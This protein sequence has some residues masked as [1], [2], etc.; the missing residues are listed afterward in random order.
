MSKDLNLSDFRVN[1]LFTCGNRN[2]NANNIDQSLLSKILDSSPAPS[3]NMASSLPRCLRG[4]LKQNAPLTMDLNGAR[5]TKKGGNNIQI[6]LTRK[7]V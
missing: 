5:F 3:K 1:A 2:T 4:F 6:V 7:V